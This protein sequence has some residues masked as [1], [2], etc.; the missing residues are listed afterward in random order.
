METKHLFTGEISDD[1]GLKKLIFNYTISSK[2]TSMS[3]SVEIKIDKLQ[4]E[5]FYYN[6]NFNDL[7]LTAEDEIKYYF[8][9]WDNDQVNGSK[10]TNSKSFF[11]KELSDEKLIKQKKKRLKF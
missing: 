7:E 2:D 10:N 9:V 11:Y 4:K 6:L 5:F 1:Y 8:T 3:H